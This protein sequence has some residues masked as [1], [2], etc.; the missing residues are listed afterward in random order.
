M[1]MHAKLNGEGEY[2]AEVRTTVKDHL[3]ILRFAQQL[4]QLFRAMFYSTLTDLE[5]RLGCLFGE[6]MEA[7]DERMNDY[8]VQGL[9]L[10]VVSLRLEDEPVALPH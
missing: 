8:F 6:V 9:Q 3:D 5:H 1:L 2:V 10:N 4:W 7:T